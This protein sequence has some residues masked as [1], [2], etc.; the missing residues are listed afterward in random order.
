MTMSNFQ[1]FP[2]TGRLTAKHTPYNVILTGRIKVPGIGDCW[3][4]GTRDRDSEVCDL[5]VQSAETKAVVGTLHLTGMG[6]FAPRSGELRL[7]IPRGKRKYAVRGYLR[8][9]KFEDPKTKKRGKYVWL[10]LPEV[11]VPTTAGL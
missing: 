4:K 8:D 3:I 2:G 5:E 11:D 9:S 10:R 1:F 6:G 7:K